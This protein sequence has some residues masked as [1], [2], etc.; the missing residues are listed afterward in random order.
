MRWTLQD[1]P[2]Q[3]QQSLAGEYA[4]ERMRVLASTSPLATAR[5]L[6]TRAVH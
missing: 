4:T 5:R 3:V 2:A 1:V 6:E